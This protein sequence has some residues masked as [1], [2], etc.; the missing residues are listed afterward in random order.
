MPQQEL[1]A[2]HRQRMRQRFARQGGFSG[3]AEHEVLEYLLF[4]AIPRQDTNPLAHRLIDRFGGLCQVL[5]ASESDLMAV[6]GVGPAAA[7]LLTAVH[8]ANRYYQQNLAK[9]PRAFQNLQQVAEYMAPQF[10]GAVAEQVYALFLDDRNCPLKMEKLTEG[11]VNEAVM[12]RTQVARLAVQYHATQV[13]LAHNHPAG[14]ALPSPSDLQ[15]TRDLSNALA[16]LG[17]RFLD[18]IIVDKE[19]D[20]ISLQQS[21]RMPAAQIYT[22]QSVASGPKGQP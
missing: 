20:Y 14:T 16:S 7:R 22:A 6:E 8:A 5:E 17:V 19:G 10:F 18:H 12:A 15:F 11:T 4:L 21:G 3:F 13:V 2:N 9:A 1:H